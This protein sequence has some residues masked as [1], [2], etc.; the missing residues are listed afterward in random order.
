MGFDHH[1]GDGCYLICWAG[2]GTLGITVYRIALTLRTWY[3]QMFTVM[4]TKSPF[5]LHVCNH[6]RSL[7]PTFRSFL[8]QLARLDGSFASNMSDISSIGLKTQ[9]GGGTHL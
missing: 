3:A 2:F 8:K 1:S 6:L 9:P 4:K 5:C 7:G